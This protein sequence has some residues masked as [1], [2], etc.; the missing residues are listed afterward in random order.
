MS[1]DECMFL[2]YLNF[3]AF[4][5]IEWCPEKNNIRNPIVKMQWYV[6]VY[7]IDGRDIF[8]NKKNNNI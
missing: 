4:V 3:N 1:V 5:E 7:A 8:D 2:T 6:I